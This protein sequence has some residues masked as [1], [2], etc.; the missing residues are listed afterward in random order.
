MYPGTIGSTQGERI[1]ITP[2]PNATIIVT[3]ALLTSP[4]TTPAG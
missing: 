2:P 1:E 3:F 4:R